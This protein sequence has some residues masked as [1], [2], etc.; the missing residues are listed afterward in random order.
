[1]GAYSPEKVKDIR[2][3]T[4]DIPVLPF[5]EDIANKAQRLTIRNCYICENKKIWNPFKLN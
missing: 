2:I 5:T 3:L 4:E 1:M